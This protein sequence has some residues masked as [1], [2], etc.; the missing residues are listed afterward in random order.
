MG[1]AIRQSELFTGNNWQVIYRAFTDVNF[2]ASD[3]ASINQALRTYIQQNYPENFNDWIESDEFVILIDLL[4]WLAGTL[5]F[6]T[7]LNARE[8]FLDTAETRSAILRLARFLSY[9]PSRNQCAQGIVKLVEVQTDDDVY[10]AF[11]TNL[12]GATIQWDNPDD[13]NWFE[14]FISVL[15]S[16]F[17]STNQFGVP[18]DKGTVAGL[19]TQLYRFNNVFSDAKLDYTCS[20]AGNSMNF[21]IVNAT[22]TDG[23]GFSEQAPDFNSALN[24][25]YLN[26]GNGNSSKFTGFFFMFKQ[27][28]L[29]NALFNVS[30]PIENNV[31]A[32]NATGVNNTDVWVQTVDDNGNVLL[33]LWSKVPAIYSENITYNNYD[34]SV[35]NIFSVITQ[36]ND[37]ISLRFS[38]GRFGAV[39]TGN[40]RVFYR[41]SNGLQYQIR[42]TDMSRVSIVLPYYNR[43]GVKHN[44]TLTFSLQ[45][46]VA[47]STPRETDDQ[48]KA[49]APSVYATQNRMVT[50]EDYNTFPL[51]S[52][53]AVKI[54]ALNRVYSGHS[55]FIDLND[56]TGNYQDVNVYSD[57]GL[58]FKEAYNIYTQVPPNLSPSA[59]DIVT[60]YCQP[61]LNRQ[62]VINYAQDYL[63]A[64]K[65]QTVNNGTTWQLADTSASFNAS[66]SFTQGNEYIEVGAFLNFQLPA[67]GGTMWAVVA[68]ITGSVTA[69]P[70]LGTAGPVVL[71]A[72]VP[73]GSTLLSIVPA[74][75]S[76]LDGTIIQQMVAAIT[77]NQSFTI[78]YDYTATSSPFVLASS[79]Q[80][81]QD[82]FAL[83]TVTYS[84]GGMWSLTANGVRYV[85]ESLQNVQWY[86]DGRRTQDAQTGEEEQDLV[87]IL[88]VN[89]DYNALLTD[90]VTLSGRAF[91]KNY[92]LAVDHLYFNRDG[93]TNPLR[94]TVQLQDSN[95]TGYPDIPDLFYKVVSNNGQPGQQNYLFW[96]H[97]D[98][99]GD[100]PCTTM[101]V[102]VNEADRHSNTSPYGTV[103]FQI[104][105]ASAAY[106][107]TFW[108]QTDAAGADSGWVLQNVGAY[109]YGIG[110]GNNIAAKW[111][112]PYSSAVVPTVPEN[113]SFLWKHYAADDHRI[114]PA[115]TNINDLYILTSDYDYQVRLWIANG[116]DPN[117]IPTPPTELDLRLAF[118]QFE[119][120]RMFSDQIV[121]R[122]AVYKYLFGAGADDS[123]Q[124]TFKVVPTQST[125]L[126]DGEI[127]TQVIRAVNAYFTANLW[128][129]GDTF[130]FTELAA[131]IHQQLAT[132]ISS[133]VLVPNFSNSVFGDGFE[134]RCMSNELPISTAQVSDVQIISSN[135]SSALKIR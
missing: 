75:T 134:I 9:N 26:D 34:V 15:N 58:F 33:P 73:D 7:D 24:M 66:G 5:A 30:V 94:V 64:N 18:L 107:N 46:S 101:V 95:L 43:A 62:E 88:K 76:G 2:N 98:T 28:T 116:A 103:A 55:R 41:T 106:N 47:N 135:T 44:L 119:D 37:A 91:T 65:L 71:S 127:Q 82:M 87:R 16:S 21:E 122:P 111:Y 29:Q 68:S 23:G 27:G 74:F 92:D 1:Q 133:C 115:R 126:S 85:F 22:F 81:D 84:S 83:L 49:R 38:D 32:V 117:E 14:R 61:L 132:I 70:P 25:F 57:D 110:R 105:G 93:T 131:Y 52:N 63:L 42:P 86:N 13:P 17:V 35:R 53:L 51:Q 112:A 36:D 56:P 20:V 113:I 114:D 104:N 125:T 12:N 80:P 40:I 90:G 102:F 120:Y 50:G 8:S 109:S 130:Y 67:G 124:Y 60:L 59:S 54:K 31:L 72:T 121:W 10:D 123:L 99:Y 108:L 78:W 48:I 79:T 69:T 3:P 129:F 118:Q 39:P 4:S 45:S 77:N 89:E 128:D 100:I 96:Q 19:N 97:D 6:K 11:G